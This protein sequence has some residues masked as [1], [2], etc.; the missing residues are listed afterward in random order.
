MNKKQILTVATILVFIAPTLGP[1]NAEASSK[2]LEELTQQQTELSNHSEAINNKI[3]DKEQELNAL[4]EDKRQLQVEVANLQKDINNLTEK[5]NVQEEKIKQLEEKIEQLHKEIVRLQDQ[6]NQ[7]NERLALQARSVQTQVNPQDIVN[8]LVSAESVSDLFGRISVITQLLNA[9]QNTLQIQLED[10]L[11]LEDAENQ[12]KFEQNELEKTRTQLEVNQKQLVTQRN[13]VE[14]KITQV[15]KQHDL[16]AEEKEALFNE[17]LLIAQQ[18]N[19]LKEKAKVEQQRIAEEEQLAAEQ[20]RIAEM[21]T[22]RVK[23]S[24]TDNEVNAVTPSSN[25]SSKPVMNAPKEKDTSSGWIMPARGRLTS[26]YGWRTH[27]VYGGQRFHKGVDIA[28]SGPI[29]AARSGKV[30]TATYNS[31]LGYYV[32]IDHGDGYQSVYSHMQPNLSVSVGQEV[33]QGQQVGIM[34][35]TG[36]STGVHLDFQIIKNGSNVNP[37]PYIGL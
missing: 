33:S 32:K 27:P 16:T 13:T 26:P 29:I 25:A 22:F 20:R 10:Q 2:T 35:T 30:V 4:A 31:G 37:A 12:L 21:S 17:K 34:G 14:K 6:I 19:T 36:T 3:E 15:A 7:R 24:K 11:A 9:N 18:M 8:M 28:G 5:I 1:L 23:E